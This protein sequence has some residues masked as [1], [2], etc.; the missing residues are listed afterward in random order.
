M[1]PKQIKLMAGE[2]FGKH[3]GLAQ[4]YLF[5]YAREMQIGKE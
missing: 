1:P 2:R 4:Q 3:A 5:Y